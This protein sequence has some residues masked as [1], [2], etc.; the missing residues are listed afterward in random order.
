MNPRVFALSGLLLAPSVAAVANPLQAV[1]SR[2]PLPARLVE[3]DLVLS[4]GWTEV[5]F[6]GSRKTAT[7]EFVPQPQQTLTGIQQSPIQR[8]AVP[9]RSTS[10]DLALRHGLL[11]RLHGWMTLSHR[12]VSVHD[13]PG[14]PDGHEV[15]AAT[16]SGF[17]EPAFGIVGSLVSAEASGHYLAWEAGYQAGISEVMPQIHTRVTG[18]GGDTMQVALRGRERI[19]GLRLDGAAGWV[20]RTPIYASPEQTVAFYATAEDLGPLRIDHGDGPFLEAEALL[21]AGPLW[22]AL[23]GNWT[24]WG[25]YVERTLDGGPVLSTTQTVGAVSHRT[26]DIGA[27][28]GLQLT[29]GLAVSGGVEVPVNRGGPLLGFDDRQLGRRFSAQVATWF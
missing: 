8:L 1:R 18:F 6:G 27:T 21:Q 5:D 16:A 29:R 4:K 3:R 13:L 22:A 17:A 2:E 11:P 9:N 12:A 15:R 28:A 7:T 14:S 25:A 10:W 19:G 23:G 20:V 24:S 26:V